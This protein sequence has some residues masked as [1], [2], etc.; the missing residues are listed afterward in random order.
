MRALAFTFLLFVAACESTPAPAPPPPV[1]DAEPGKIDLDALGRSPD[2]DAALARCERELAWIALQRDARPD[3]GALRARRHHALLVLVE[4]HLAKHERGP[5]SDGEALRAADENLALVDF[6]ALPARYDRA[7]ARLARALIGQARAVATGDPEEALLLLASAE[8]WSHRAGEDAAAAL[9]AARAE[10][11][12]EL[13]AHALTASL[14][15]RRGGRYDEAERLAHEARGRAGP[16]QLW[17]AELALGLALYEAGATYDAV[18]AFERACAALDGRAGTATSGASEPWLHAAAAHFE[19]SRA[20]EGDAGPTDPAAFAAHLEAS[21]AAAR[22]GLAFVA[23]RSLLL[24][25]EHADEHALCAEHRARLY[26]FEYRALRALPGRAAEAE[27]AL[28]GMLG[29]APQDA[30]LHYALGQLLEERE[31]V[32]AARESYARAYGLDREHLPTRRALG[33]LAVARS[34]EASDL[35]PEE[36]DK[37]LETARLHLSYVAERDPGREVYAAL[38]DVA[39]ARGDDAAAR[40]WEGRLRALGD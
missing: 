31:A 28:R 20:Y 21:L 13:V 27:D 30:A 7:C 10:A 12:E 5:D 40:R 16:A 3:D 15:A 25:R 14:L 1:P 11:S 2:L 26:R 33:F 22:D 19:L 18:Q 4:L 24:P 34:R 39:R 6:A 17:R 36:R 23:E 29:R 9:D 32:D 35:S 37:A 38:R 8:H